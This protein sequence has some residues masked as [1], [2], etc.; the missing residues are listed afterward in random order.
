[1][2]VRVLG[3]SASP[4]ADSNSDILLRQ[5]L[6]GAESAGA[7]VEY[8]RLCDFSIAPCS[9]CNACYATGVCIIKDD[10][11]KLSAKLLNTQRLIFATPVFFMNV[12]AQAKALI[13]RAQCHWAHRYV[14][15]RELITD[16]ANRRAM[17]IA[18][19]GSKSIKMFES[20]RLTMK[21]YFDTL[22]MQYVGGLFVNKINAA[23]EIQ[24]HPPALSEAH[25]LGK[26]LITASAL[27]EKPIN[28][29]L[30]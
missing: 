27:P 23:G 15:K 13:D 16:A 19:G 30:T 8:I 12:C 28:I 2:S 3:I 7:S 20:V 29:E 17:V 5:A 24:T 18:V 10:Y 9:E 14:L 1:M 21:S 11:Q 6:A 22:Q 4:R 26:E 25:R